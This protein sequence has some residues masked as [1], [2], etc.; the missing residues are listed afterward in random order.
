MSDVNARDYDDIYARDTDIY[1]R[2]VDEFDVYA[3]DIDEIFERDLKDHIL[4]RREAS[5]DILDQFYKREAEILN[6]IVRRAKSHT[7]SDSE[8]SEGSTATSKQV[9]MTRQKTTKDKTMKVVGVNGCTAIFL[10]GKGFITGA[11]ASPTELSGR[12]KSAGAEANGNGKVTSV[13]I[14]AP[15][16]ADGKKAEAAIKEVVKGAPV[17]V[18]S[19][20]IDTSANAG[21]WEFSANVD[22]PQFVTSTHIK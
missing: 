15:D 22:K 18:H 7:S 14:V 3:R 10:F 21:F 19:Y 9:G 17:L 16:A 2:D 6:D 1:D 13:T 20:K 4:S 11:H 12:A 5:L 8:W